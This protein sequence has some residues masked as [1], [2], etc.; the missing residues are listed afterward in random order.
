M[1]DIF[2]AT[3]SNV[4]SCLIFKYNFIEI[5]IFRPMNTKSILVKVM[6]RQTIV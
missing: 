2:Q 4:F 1:T 6:A 3:F 5:Y